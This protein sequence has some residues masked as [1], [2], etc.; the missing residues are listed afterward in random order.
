MFV[1]YMSPL[2]SATFLP[3]FHPRAGEHASLV[4][5]GVSTQFSLSGMPD[6]LTNIC[7]HQEALE[8]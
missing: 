7:G 5:R 1:P 4:I 8:T 3:C 6:S 2:Q